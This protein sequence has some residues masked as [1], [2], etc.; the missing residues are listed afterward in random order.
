MTMTMTMM[1]FLQWRRAEPVPAHAAPMAHA[2]P[3]ATELSAA[4]SAMTHEASALG[5]ETAEV[6]GVIDDANGQATRQAQAIEALASQFGKI[7]QAQEAIGGETALGLKAVA[8]VRGAVEQVGVEVS[9]IVDSLH[10]VSDAAGQI[11]QIALQTRLVA[12]NASVEAKRAGDAGRGFGVVADA[13]KDLAARVEASSK[14]IM[15][16]VSQ[17]D[18]RIAALARDIQRQP[19]GQPQGPVH[20]ALVDVTLGVERIRQSATQSRGLSS[21]LSASLVGIQTEMRATM[22]MLGGAPCSAPRPCS[23]CPST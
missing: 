5:R 13:V 7:N 3:T 4:L 20:T 6:R 11:T 1:S 9:A 19:D 16:T 10:E 12:F 21:D 18:A 23:G 14:Q 15:G 22:G 2:G 8:C 17:L